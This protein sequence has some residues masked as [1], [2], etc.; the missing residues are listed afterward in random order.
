M[1]FWK[2]G[3][4]AGAFQE[5]PEP[6][7]NLKP[8]WIT[9]GDMKSWGIIEVCKWFL[10]MSPRWLRQ[11]RLRRMSMISSGVPSS[12]SS[13]SIVI[14]AFLFN[15]LLILGVEVK[16]WGVWIGN[17]SEVIIRGDSLQLFFLIGSV[18]LILWRHDCTLY[19]CEY[20]GFR[21]GYLWAWDLSGR[22]LNVKLTD[23]EK[24]YWLE[25][26]WKVGREKC[27]ALMSEVG[28]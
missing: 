7:I 12:R 22:L 1:V 18:A 9:G 26:W 28:A 25:L 21:C 8:N 14:W 4:D 15:N 3:V 27:E 11:K 2:F 10:R 17:L 19:R 24:F 6:L 13:F 23:N 16:I 20:K 5:I